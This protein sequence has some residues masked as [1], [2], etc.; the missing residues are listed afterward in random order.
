[1]DNSPAYIAAKAESEKSQAQLAA[2]QANSGS[3][4]ADVTAQATQAMQAGSAAHKIESDALIADPSTA[5]ALQKLTA[6][7]KA[8]N[9]LMQK[10]HD[11]MIKSPDYV[12][13]KT[14]VT[15]ADKR[16][17]EAERSRP[18]YVPA[19]ITAKGK[20]TAVSTD[21]FTIYVAVRRT[22]TTTRPS[23]TPPA[24]PLVAYPTRRSTSP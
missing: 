6:S 7:Q 15:A 8:M 11:E 21:S 3:S 2:L 18:G 5:A 1:M 16:L 10:F 9:E 20:I 4:D 17:I 12:A 23:T 22:R 19:I 24:R 14:V 13:A